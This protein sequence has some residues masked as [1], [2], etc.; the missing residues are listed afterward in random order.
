MVNVITMLLAN[1]GPELVKTIVEVVPWPLW[2]YMLS[3][4][5]DGVS[6]SAKAPAAAKVRAHAMKVRIMMV[7]FLEVAAPGGR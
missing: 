7:D 3:G 4:S 6:V 5:T 1:P 2:A